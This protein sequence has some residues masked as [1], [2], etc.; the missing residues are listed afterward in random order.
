MANRQIVII[1]PALA[2]ANNGNWQTAARWQHFLSGCN[3]VQVIG[4]DSANVAKTCATADV[5]IALHARRSAEALRIVDALHPRPRLVLVL[6][7]TD[8]YR[9][10]HIDPQA[11]AS[12][13]LADRLVVLQPAGLDALDPRHRA[14]AEVIFQSAPALPSFSAPTGSPFTVCMIG[15]LREEKD[16]LCFLQAAQ[17]LAGDAPSLPALR[18]LH[19]G[20]ALDPALGEQAARAMQQL[21]HYR[22]LGNLDHAAAREVLRTSQL[23]VITSRM[24][25]GANVIIEAVTSGVPV[26]AS[27]ISGNRGMLGA[28][29]A[30]TFPLGDSAAL[31]DA[32][33]RAM[34]DARFLQILRAQC[35][36]RAPLFA[37][38]REK[39][40]VRRL[41]DN[42]S[43]LST[44]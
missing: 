38:E 32:I 34:T 13:D 40:A 27:D 1:S 23:M 3:T 35:A 8:L 22:W 28:D 20:A 41:M 37:P 2:K 17:L 44:E 12:L 30:G 21:P 36:A 16:P 5:V 7:G 19:V 9:D 26:L 14:K 33:R 18:M 11:R 42:V 31:A 10:I 24:E 15:H 4:S 29:Y 6:T 43:S 25:G 39:A